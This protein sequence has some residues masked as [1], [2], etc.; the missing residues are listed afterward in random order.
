M[1]SS[2]RPFAAKI[3]NGQQEIAHGIAKKK[4]HAI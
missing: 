2:L 1:K 3:S 4:H